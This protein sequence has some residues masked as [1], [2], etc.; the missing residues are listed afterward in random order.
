M[1]HSVPSP[2]RQLALLAL[3]ASAFVAC[4]SGGAGAS[5]AGAGPAAK[6]AIPAEVTAANIALG[7]SLFNNGGCIRCHGRAGVGAANGPALNDQS[8]DQLATGS[9]DEIVAVITTG[10]PKE[11]VKVATRPQAMQP[12]G[13]RMALTDAQIKAVAAYVWKLSHP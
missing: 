4:R 7:D 9:Y 1:P 11:K 8:W 3:A 10:V 13:G 12:R 2:L 6:T 5:G